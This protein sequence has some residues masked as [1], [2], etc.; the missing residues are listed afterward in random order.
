MAFSGLKFVSISNHSVTSMLSSPYCAVRRRKYS[1]AVPQNT[2]ISS[3]LR[4]QNVIDIK[5][6]HLDLPPFREKF[7]HTVKITA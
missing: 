3:F 4:K 7:L 2:D 6:S 1:R 5:I